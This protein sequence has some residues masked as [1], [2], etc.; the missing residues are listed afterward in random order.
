[1]KQET[2]WSHTFLTE[3]RVA[4]DGRKC[5]MTENY[6]NPKGNTEKMTQIMFETFEV[7]ALYLESPAV[8]ALYASG[9]STGLSLD[10]GHSVTSCI[11]VYEGYTLPHAISRLD[12][13]GQDV[14]RALKELLLKKMPELAHYS[15]MIVVCTSVRFVMRVQN[16]FHTYRQVADMKE[17]L[18]YVALDYQLETQRLP[19]AV[20]KEYEM[21][22][23]QQ[24]QV[25]SERYGC[26]E[27]LLNY[28][29]NLAAVVNDV[30]SKCDVDIRK[31][32]YGN[33]VLSGGATFAPGFPERFQMDITRLVSKT[34]SVKIIAP[35][36]RKYSVWIGG[37]ILA[38]LETFEDMWIPKHEY[39]E[40][41]PSVVWRRCANLCPG[42]KRWAQETR[43]AQHDDANAQE[44]G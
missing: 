35:P 44:Q 29:H 27:S 8:L 37:S 11:P 17:K 18:S 22:D 25:E 10:C 23:G 40:A 19:S 31:D 12:V 13:G 30:I 3:L 7:P 28:K 39:D 1:M 32:L 41:G 38:S 33:I 21:P 42:D 4:A 9:R 6:F 2:I 16:D 26:Y 14:T 5:L 36:E 24:I 15:P 34:T 20:S 43:P